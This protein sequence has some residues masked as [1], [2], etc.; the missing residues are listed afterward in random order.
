MD[1]LNAWHKT[2]PGLLVFGVV[3]L[4][5]AYGFFCLSVDRGNLWWYAGTTIFLIGGLRN[6]LVL[7]TRRTAK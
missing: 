5:A 7:V 1:K 2:A 4:A 3:E 6:F